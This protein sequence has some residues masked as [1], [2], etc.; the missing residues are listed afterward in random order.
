MT[1]YKNRV[2]DDILKFRL[3]VFGAVL[4]S[5]PKGCG[6]TRT[7]SEIAKTKIEFQDEEKRDYYLQLANNYPLKLLEGAKPILFDEWQDAPKIWG[8][9][10]KYCDDHPEELGNFI[11]TGSSSNN[12]NT[13][14]TGTLRISELEMIPMSLFE[15]G[16]SNGKISLIHLFDNPKSFTP[17]E[18]DIDIDDIIFSICRGGWPKTLIC[19][20]KEEQLYI[21][22]D[23]LN[24]TCKKDMSSL[25]GIKRNPKWVASILKSYS[26]NLCTLAD[27]KTIYQ[28]AF[29]NCGLSES[30]F[31]E[32][33]NALERLNIIKDVSS[34][35]PLLRSKTNVRSGPKRNL[36]DP[37]IAAVALG[38]TPER[39]KSDFKTLGFLFESLC[40]RDL[41]AY[42]AKNNGELSYYHDRYD[43]EADCVLH[44]NDGRYA[45]IEIKL[46]NDQIDDG[47]KH[48]CEIESLVKK[49]NDK[50]PNN[51]MPLP[52]LKI[53]LTGTRYSSKR[54]DGVFVIPIGCLKD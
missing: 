50:Y 37:S 19:N 43:L 32:Y 16:E 4:I 28:D 38:A 52:T 45:L 40:I 31:F 39:L 11:L 42:S 22:R 6:K 26:R 14:H 13:P 46:G 47:A 20:S 21:A 1:A 10:R 41:S 27:T 36:I 18:S 44:L 24:Q 15:T 25:D 33:V 29:L 35:S 30:S 3:K 17:C 53:I 54:D 48:L 8:V 7:A 49:F 2:F 23:L 12:V 34:W 5:G 9:I 51:K